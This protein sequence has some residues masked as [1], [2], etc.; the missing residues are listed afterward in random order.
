[1]THIWEEREREEIIIAPHLFERKEKMADNPEKP[2]PI[3]TCRWREDT[4]VP[5]S[6]IA[7]G[8]KGHQKQNRAKTEQQRK[9]NR[10]MG[11]REGKNMHKNPVVYEEEE[12]FQRFRSEIIEACETSCIFF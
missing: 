3:Q 4:I 11:G 8:K 6:V 5:C 10:R 1:M 7:R 9:I 2:A 12:T